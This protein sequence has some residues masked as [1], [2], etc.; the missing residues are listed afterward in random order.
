MS[1]VFINLHLFFSSIMEMTGQ[2]ELGIALLDL[3]HVMGSNPLFL[4]LLR[5]DGSN[6][7]TKLGTHFSILKF[8]T[9]IDKRIDT[10]AGAQNGFELVTS[11]FLRARAE[12]RPRNLRAMLLEYR[13][14]ILES[15]L[16]NT[17]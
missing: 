2:M 15:L 6:M 14:R 7:D 5:P 9:A 13:F 11:R 4:S 8:V 12:R 1:V 17:P 10:M 16:E 3:V